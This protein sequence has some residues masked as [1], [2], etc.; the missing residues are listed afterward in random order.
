MAVENIKRESKDKLKQ[1]GIK[2]SNCYYF[3]NI[4]RF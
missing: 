2:N 1:V 4:I 3:D